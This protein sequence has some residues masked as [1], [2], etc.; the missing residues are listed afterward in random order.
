MS[1]ISE[2]YAFVT[3]KDEQ[4]T[5]IGLKGGRFDGVIYKYGEVKIIEPQT[6]DE[7]PV[8]QFDWEIV[9]S[10][11]LPKKAMDD[12]FFSL[13]GDVLVDI[14][15]NHYEFGEEEIDESDD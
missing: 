15:D 9:D 14:I 1:D 5:M 6:E 11:G 2:K 3:D 7:E 13:L 10:N 12:E 4:W 8:L